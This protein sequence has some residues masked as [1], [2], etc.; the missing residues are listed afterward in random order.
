LTQTSLRRCALGVASL[1]LAAG[2]GP[3]PKVELPTAKV[4]GTVKYEGH[5]IPKGRIVFM[6]ERGDL[7]AGDFGADGK[8]EAMVPVG[9]NQVMIDAK[10]S[11]FEAAP[12]SGVRGMETFTS[13]VPDHYG[14]FS[15]S[16]LKLD[17]PEAG[18][19]FD[20]PIPK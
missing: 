2:C 19:T 18:T 12:K 1:I 13:Y 7:T 14:D 4:T 8:Y 6:H 10:K 17:V 15:T 3:E 20:V 9:K 11:S 5:E 16:K